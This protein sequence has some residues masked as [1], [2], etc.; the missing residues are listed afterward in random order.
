MRTHHWWMANIQRTIRAYPDLRARK[1]A[2]QP[3]SVTASYSAD[4]RGGGAGRSTEQ[5][6]LRWLAPGEEQ[7]LDAVEKA[8]DDADTRTREIRE[9]IKMH[10]WRGYT[11]TAVSVR[12]CVSVGTLTNWNGWVCR[13]VAANLGLYQEKR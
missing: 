3:Q 9:F 11:M 12:M 4:P 7:A 2:M 10:Y 8:L 6:A 13:R 5:A 1:D